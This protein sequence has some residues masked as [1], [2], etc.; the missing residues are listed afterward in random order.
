MSSAFIQPE[1]III[2]GDEIK[3]DFEQDCLKSAYPFELPLYLNYGSKFLSTMPLNELC[4]NIHSF[5]ESKTSTSTSTP[6]S[7]S[8][9][10]PTYTSTPT[11]TLSIN[12]VPH[13]CLWKVFIINLKSSVWTKFTIRVYRNRNGNENGFIVHMN[14]VN[15]F[16]ELFQSLYLECNE[17]VGTSSLSHLFQ[18]DPIF[19]M[20]DHE[21]NLIYLEPMRSNLLTNISHKMLGESVMI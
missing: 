3:T 10:T 21:E 9:S 14:H 12:F 11:S 4:E 5:L 18:V 17:I 8:T 2:I 1:E 13:G 20:F 19:I 6:T 15:G 16:G 7:T